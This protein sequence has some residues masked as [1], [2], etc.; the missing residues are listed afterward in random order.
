MPPFIQYFFAN[1]RDSPTVSV[2]DKDKDIVILR[3][4][5]Q[6]KKGELIMRVHYKR[7]SSTPRTPIKTNQIYQ[8][9]AIITTGVSNRS[10]K[11]QAITERHTKD[12]RVID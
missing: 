10:T 1:F 12:K 5:Q 3:L 9:Y 6:K 2:R 11:R 7:I 8:K 4:G